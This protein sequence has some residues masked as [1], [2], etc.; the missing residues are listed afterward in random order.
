MHA[1][2]W[3][4]MLYFFS[5]HSYR[6]FYLTFNTSGCFLCIYAIPFNAFRKATQ[7]HIHFLKLPIEPI[8][9]QFSSVKQTQ[10]EALKVFPHFFHSVPHKIRDICHCLVSLTEIALHFTFKYTCHFWLTSGR[11]KPLQYS[12][13]HY[14]PL[15]SAVA[16][17][18]I[19]QTW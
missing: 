11:P 7:S 5:F 14:A 2:L 18:S 16:V 19:P 13:L 6:F 15:V 3:T 12:A 17:P 1:D 10:L 9:V 8:K 4:Y